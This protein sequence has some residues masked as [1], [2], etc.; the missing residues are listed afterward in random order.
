MSVLNDSQIPIREVPHQRGLTVSQR[1]RIVVGSRKH[2]RSVS[3][4][5]RTVSGIIFSKLVPH[6]G[7]ETRFEPRR[8]G[9]WGW[10]RDQGAGAAV[11][12]FFRMG[13]GRGVGWSCRRD[14]IIEGNY[15]RE[16]PRLDLAAGALLVAP[17]PLRRR[18][19]HS[20]QH[21]LGG[22][23]YRRGHRLGD[24]P[25]TSPLRLAH[26]PTGADNWGQRFSRAS[27]PCQV[28]CPTVW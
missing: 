20:F 19:E 6:G 14:R 2:Q 22:V 17:L 27:W 21:A 26:G 15:I 23:R 7:T 1:Y 9:G 16:C 28:S 12:A 24:R 8:G 10:A 18:G 25:A 11:F 13:R 3:G 4:V 5:D